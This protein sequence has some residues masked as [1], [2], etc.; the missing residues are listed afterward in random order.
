MKTVSLEFTG[1]SGSMAYA[2]GDV[3]AATGKVIP[4][5][6]AGLFE[7]NGKGGWIGRVSVITNAPSITPRIKV[8]FYKND[9]AIVAADNAPDKE[10]YTELDKY[11][12]FIELPTM[13]SSTDTSGSMSWTRDNN[14]RIPLVPDSGSSALGF[15]LSAIDAFNSIASQKWTTNVTVFG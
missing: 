14:L 13:V 10:I 9:D 1:P 5:V 11:L 3:I 12:D 8:R 6:L 4:Y 7:K 2:A 15:S